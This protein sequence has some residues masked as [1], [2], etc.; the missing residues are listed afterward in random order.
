MHDH[1]S[2]Y[3]TCAADCASVWFSSV[4]TAKK[5]PTQWA[6]FVLHGH[7]VIWILLWYLHLPPLI[8]PFPISP[9]STSLS[10]RPSFSFLVLSFSYLPSFCLLLPPLSS[11]HPINPSFSPL[12]L[13][14][15]SVLKS[16]W[17]CSPAPGTT[18]LKT[19]RLPLTYR[20]KYIHKPE[21]E[22]N[23]RNADVASL[24]GSSIT[25]LQSPGPSAFA[26][27]WIAAQMW[28]ICFL[29]YVQMPRQHHHKGNT[30]SVCV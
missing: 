26:P 12:V 13:P 1:V 3:K 6:A 24:E 29:C 22:K 4:Q 9:S 2:G 10:F 16:H 25:Q 30:A 21:Q 7:R 8:A 14:S 11:L 19:T 5:R 23:V 15:G 18:S 28:A 27:W 20:N 17:Q